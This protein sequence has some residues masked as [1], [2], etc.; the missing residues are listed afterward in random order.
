MSEPAHAVVVLAAGGSGRLGEPKQL[1]MID[2]EPLV[3]RAARI[4]LETAPAQALV[5]VGAR[6]DAIWGAIADLP[7]TRVACDDWSAGLSA[8]IRAGVRALDTEVDAALFV[9]CDQPS[10]DAAHLR[11]LTAIWRLDPE[12]AVASSY[13]GTL[14]VPA[15]LPRSWFVDLDTLTA[16]RGARDLLRAR[17][18]E[19]L[20]V[21]AAALARDVDLPADL[22]RMRAMRER[23]RRP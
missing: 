4:A 3:R 22:D 12:R 19:V 8:S 10:L 16:D 9:L 15:I 7:L 18:A 11:A 13:A 21:R 23:E 17:S 2:G 14:G 1:V 5:V 20:G 6:S